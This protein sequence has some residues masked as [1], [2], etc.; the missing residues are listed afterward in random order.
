MSTPVFA[1]VYALVLAASVAGAVLVPAVLA[2]WAGEA[3]GR[4]GRGGVIAVAVGLAAWFGIT[5]A[6]A[7]AG[8]YSAAAST[9][10][11]FPLVGLGLL[12]P[13]VAVLAAI[14][15]VA[16]IR[17]L[18]WDPAVQP[19]LIA[20]ESYRVIAGAVFLGLMFLGQLPAVFAIPAGAGD[21][22][23]GLTAFWA[24][25]SLR[26]G[27]LGAAATWNLLGM[28]DLVVAV[29]LG[30]ATT[31]GPLRFISASPSTVL[32]SVLPMVLVPTFLVPISFLIHVVS[33]RHLLRRRS[34]RFEA[35]SS[36]RSEM[37]A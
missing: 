33:V 5:S 35:L 19:A 11:G 32:L 18:V 3:G 4:R 29:G 25:A 36:S 1:A 14:W 34:Q 12:V 15:L 21:V 23:I 2:G 16:P 10:W 31:P 9:R 8:G 22:L 27:R 24:A 7:A 17:R 6:V 28:L 37:S 13:L 26:S 20:V 30:V